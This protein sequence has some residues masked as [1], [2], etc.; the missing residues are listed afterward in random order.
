VTEEEEEEMERKRRR[1]GIWDMG[2]ATTWGRR[3][4]DFPAQLGRL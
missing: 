4:L 2:E 3:R 1:I